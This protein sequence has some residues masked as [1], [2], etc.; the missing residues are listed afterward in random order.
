[1][2]TPYNTKLGQ[3]NM[4][5]LALQISYDNNCWWIEPIADWLLTAKSTEIFYCQTF[6]LY[7]TQ[8]VTQGLK[9]YTSVTLLYYSVK[10][11]CKYNLTLLEVMNNNIYTLAGYNPYSKQ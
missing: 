7:G 1:M 3:I 8:L 4:G 10:I 5:G 6:V 2:S 9:V 11:S